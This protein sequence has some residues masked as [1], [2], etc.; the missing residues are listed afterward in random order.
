MVQYLGAK[1]VARRFIM[2]PQ[3]SLKSISTQVVTPQQ[4]DRVV[5]GPQTLGRVLCY[6]L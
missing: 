2:F 1:E 4:M 6:F 5:E 3:H